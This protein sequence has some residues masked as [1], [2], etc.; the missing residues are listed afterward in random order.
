MSGLE[1][2]GAIASATQLAEQGIKIISSLARICEKLRGAQ[3]DIAEKICQVDHLVRLTEAVKHNESLQTEEIAAVLRPCV[4]KVTRLEDLLKTV[5]VGADDGRLQCW[6]K[7]I[8][9]IRKGKTVLKI[10]QE[11]EYY[12]TSLLLLIESL[13]AYV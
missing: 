8:T 4:K 11:I 2:I 10:F 5:E 3:E 12:K 7:K 9:W 13:H 1:V 6:T